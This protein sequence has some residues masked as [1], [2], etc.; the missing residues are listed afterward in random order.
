MLKYLGDGEF[1]TGPGGVIV[2]PRDLTDAEQ[3]E[4]AAVIAA[5]PRGDAL[6]REMKPSTKPAGPAKES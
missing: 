3:K 2:P 4:H 5:A 1:I 6:Y